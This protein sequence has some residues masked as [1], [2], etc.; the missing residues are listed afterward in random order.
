MTILTNELFH[1]T[2]T[3]YQKLAQLSEPIKQYLEVKD[4][5]YFNV[6]RDGDLAIIH[7]NYEWM[8]GYIEGKYYNLDPHI[9]HPDNMLA[10]FCVLLIKNNYKYEH[11]SD[12]VLCE[13]KDD[14]DYGFT[15]VE[16]GNDNFTAFCFTVDK[17][18]H[19]FI[20][21]L[22]N[23]SEIIKFLIQKLD[24]QIRTSFL[25]LQQ[26]KVQVINLKGDLFFQQRGIVFFE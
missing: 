15:Y 13:S 20:N 16:K 14:F 5:T 24:Y 11:Y 7:S 19:K 12:V 9:V 25:E 2:K 4:V 17:N 1:G 3:Y 8:E 23:Q 18:N 10:G 26:N 6:H 22:F 21:T